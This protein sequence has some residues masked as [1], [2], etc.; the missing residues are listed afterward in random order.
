MHT[1]TNHSLFSVTTSWSKHQ[2]SQYVLYFSER[3][4]LQVVLPL[5]FLCLIVRLK[6][7]LHNENCS[8]IRYTE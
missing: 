7:Q 2:F 4:T 6:L 5:D 1:L 8:N 3:C